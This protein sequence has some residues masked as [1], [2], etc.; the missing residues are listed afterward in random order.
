MSSSQDRLERAMRLIGETPS[1]GN[2]RK[3]KSDEPTVSQRLKWLRDYLAIDADPYDFT[4]LVSDY[5]EW[6]GE[7]P[8]DTFDPDDPHD[9]FQTPDGEAIEKDF[10]AWLKSDGLD[11]F[12]V[13]ND[14]NAPAYLHFDPRGVV[15]SGEWL[16]HFSDDAS[17]IARKGFVHG[18]PDERTLGLTTWFVDSVRKSEPGWNFGF[19]ASSPDAIVAAQERKY[20]RHAVLFQAPGVRAHHWGDEEEQ[21]I[22]WGPS[23]R[24][25]I[26]LYREDGS[27]HVEDAKTG[28][29]VRE[30]TFREVSSWAMEHFDARGVNIVVK[31]RRERSLA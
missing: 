29:T 6:L 18:H 4:Y 2:P 8:P 9:F 21:V 10:V 30:G 7:D 22:F 12:E 5:Y 24:R 25:F 26:P 1:V 16:V 3:K 19:I 27:W 20:G 17:D 11:Q 28:D 23:A 14:A 31:P 13:S 15:E